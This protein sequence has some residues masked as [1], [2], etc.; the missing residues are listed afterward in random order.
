MSSAAPGSPYR[1]PA[2][3]PPATCVE[4]SPPDADITLKDHQL[5]RQIGI[6]YEAGAQTDVGIMT[7]SSTVLGIFDAA[8]WLNKKRL[9]NR[10]VGVDVC[11]RGWGVGVNV[12]EVYALGGDIKHIG[13][14]DAE[15]KYPLCIT[16]VPGTTMNLDFNRDQVAKSG[17][18]LPPV[19]KHLMGQFAIMHTH[20]S[21]F[22]RCA[23][24]N[25]PCTDSSLGVSSGGY[26]SA[27]HIAQTDPLFAKRIREGLPH[28]NVLDW[29]VRKYYWPLLPLLSEAGNTAGNTNRR[30]DCIQTIK[31][32]HTH[33]AAYVADN[34]PVDWRAVK[35][36]V[37]KT[38]PPCMSILGEMCQYVARVSGGRSGQFLDQLLQVWKSGEVTSHNK[39]LPGNFLKALAN[40][41]VQDGNIMPM[42]RNFCIIANLA[43][44][45]FVDGLAQ[46]ITAS[47]VGTAFGGKTNKEQAHL[48]SCNDVLV[49]GLN[50]IANVER[51]GFDCSTRFQ[52]TVDGAELLDCSKLAFEF[53]CKVARC[54]VSKQAAGEKHN[55]ADSI[56]AWLL[57]VL[58]KM[59]SSADAIAGDAGLRGRWSKVDLKE[60][61]PASSSLGVDEEV[62]LEEI[63]PSGL[64]ADV[65]ST[66]R[67][68]GLQLGDYVQNNETGQIYLLEKIKEVAAEDQKAA[69]EMLVLTPLK[70]AEDQKTQ[71]VGV[72]VV[73][74]SYG[75]PPPGFEKA[76]M[77]A[78]PEWQTT[79]PEHTYA[80]RACIAEADMKQALAELVRMH[81]DKVAPAQHMLNFSGQSGG[82]RA[83]A[84]IAKKALV[85]VPFTN[86]VTTSAKDSGVQHPCVMNPLAEYTTACEQDEWAPPPAAKPPAGAP[87][88][89]G[90]QAAAPQSLGGASLSAQE[91]ENAAQ[92][93][94]G[95]GDSAAFWASLAVDDSS[96]SGT[97]QGEVARVD[98]DAGASAPRIEIRLQSPSLAIGVPKTAAKGGQA[99]QSCPL[100]W[101][102]QSTPDEKRANVAVDWS[103]VRWVATVKTQGT[104]SAEEEAA[105]KAAR[106][107]EVRIPVLV[108]HKEIAQGDAIK[109]FAPPEQKK[110]PQQK[111][112]S[113]AA[114][115]TK[116][117]ERPNRTR[118]SSVARQA[119]PASKRRRKGA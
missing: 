59:S 94:H 11:N 24:A 82:V 3:P 7:W 23:E 43:G 104:D 25:L 20:L 9:S 101:K 19:D 110:T 50:L 31:R 49:T 42:M 40:A 106:V 55:S 116:A 87:P 14:N 47:D 75:R 39:T 84:N 118:S 17:N 58:R 69:G 60:N 119:A 114:L 38:K 71:E 90:P 22:L 26:L 70:G 54:L 72:E 112:I 115:L 74:Q 66:L 95:D 92:T 76:Y 67:R 57:S 113:E 46:T 5:L 53:G 91:E 105:A 44:D 93:Q 97:G 103:T 78:D 62:R 96:A 37:A 65:V 111:Q 4:L 61:K 30:P 41:P 27:E 56:G 79:A 36:A 29:K 33:A 89:L 48:A 6:D 32:I 13:F 88:A 34:A 52:P 77:R 63:A 83:T 80:W 21:Q 2:C 99:G 28:W 15:V 16:E 109:Y 117:L 12:A 81:P 35:T 100:Y 108:N 10:E 107:V 102:V 98:V 73:V 85:L 51:A 86:R 8:G 18:R 68:Q 45:V 1:V 64:S